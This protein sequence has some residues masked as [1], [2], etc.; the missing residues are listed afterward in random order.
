VVLDKTF[1]E[2]SAGQQIGL[3]IEHGLHAQL[4]FFEWCRA[5]GIDPT[6]LGLGRADIVDQA[7]KEA[8]WHKRWEVVEP[9]RKKAE[10]LGVSSFWYHRA[11]LQLRAARVLGRTT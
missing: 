1:R 9:L 8:L 11:G 2:G 7:L 4:A 3:R 10:E 5:R 6:F